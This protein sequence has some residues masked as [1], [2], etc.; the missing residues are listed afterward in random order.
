MQRDLVC[1]AQSWC[2]RSAPQHAVG[3]GRAGV[4]FSGRN[5]V[6]CQAPPSARGGALPDDL[7][8]PSDEQVQLTLPPALAE[9]ACTTQK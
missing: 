3:V 4:G 6:C 1:S 5:D 2:V 9:R 8:G 7:Y